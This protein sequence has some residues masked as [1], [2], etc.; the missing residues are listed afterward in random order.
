[1]WWI[2]LVYDV[3]E[4]KT[5]NKIEKWINFI[6]ENSKIDEKALILVGNKIDI[7]ERQVTKEEGKEFA[8]KYNLE[9][10]ETSAKTGEGIEKAFNCIYKKL[11]DLKWNQKKRRIIKV[12]L[13]IIKLMKKI[14]AKILDLIKLI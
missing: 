9:Y 5:L 3:N 11:Y 10:F 1:M 8:K 2:L 6:K 4:K 13:T 7:D 14:K 12:I